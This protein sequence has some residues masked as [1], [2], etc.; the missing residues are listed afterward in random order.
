MFGNSKPVVFKPYSRRRASRRP[1][2]WLVLLLAGVT[3]GAGGVLVAQERYLP[4]RLSAE[5][6]AQLNRAY[7]Q[8]ER[9]RLGLAGELSTATE[10]LGTALAETKRLADELAA[11]RASAAQWRDDLTTAV[12]AL[13]PD[14]R[15][16]AVEVRAARFTARGGVLDYEVVLTRRAATDRSPA[17]PWVGVMQLVLEGESERGSP[18]R[19]TLKPTAL[20]IDGLQVLRGTQPL[21]DDFK[22]RQATIQ[23]LDRSAGQLLGMRVLRVSGP[24]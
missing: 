8:S 5:A 10:Q 21:P 13:P 18:N 4:P 11:S 20:S 24:A 3:V 17:K 9:D 22:P 14:P 2:R 1:P 23:V 15:G 16:S 12:A 6:S 19:I 7:E